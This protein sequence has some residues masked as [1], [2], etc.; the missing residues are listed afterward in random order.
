MTNIRHRTDIDGLRGIAVLAVLFFHAGYSIASGGYVGVDVFFVLSGFLVA[1]S[2]Q[3]SIEKNKFSLAD[4]YK[5]RILRIIPAA[6][7]VSVIVSIVG[8]KVLF[9]EELKELFTSVFYFLTLRANVWAPTAVS[10]FGIEVIYKPLIHFWSLS[11]EFQYYIIFPIFINFLLQHKKTKSLMI[12]SAV[13]ILVSLAYATA[14]TKVHPNKGYFSSIL[15]MW[16]FSLGTILSI[17]NIRHR[18]NFNKS[19]VNNALTGLGILLISFAIFKFNQNSDFPGLFALVPC[20]GTA[21]ILIFS[22]NK[23][24]FGRLLSFSGLRFVGIISF[25]LYLVHQPILA[26]F[27]LIEGRNLY[28]HETVIAITASL[29]LAAILYLLVERRYRKKIKKTSAIVLIAMYLI[30]CGI[31][32][33]FINGGISYP[34]YSSNTKNYLKYRNDNNPRVDECR[35]S[36]GVIIP[37]KACLYGSST[38]PKVALWGDSHAD[39]IVVPLSKEFEKR[40]YSVKEF[41]IAGCP[42]LININA[43]SPGRRCVENESLIFEYLKHHKEIKHVILMAYW[44]G[45][46]DENLAYPVDAKNEGRYTAI[47]NSF[48]DVVKGLIDSGKIVHIVYPTPKMKVDPPLFMARRELLFDGSFDGNVQLTQKEFSKQKMHSE[49]ILDRIS[50]K[51][52]VDTLHIEKFLYNRKLSS[53]QAVDGKVVLYRDD[54]HLS[55]TGGAIKVS[56]PMVDHILGQ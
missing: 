33:L 28:A 30:L 40:G 18:I 24:F 3:A 21:L 56:K 43:V 10:Y 9:P 4:F 53:Y 39:Q 45:Y 8:F 26:Y 32:Y 48:R 14:Y 34:T 6:L 2:I 46:I 23:L 42:P 20:I 15:R 17:S 19:V 36:G 41:A 50:K 51:Y 25:S 29:V 47:F 11:V 37:E 44:I 49:N 31:S 5:R 38:L 27:R 54:N 35:V 55:M 7:T 12:L 1:G 52:K 13:I 16:E 22:D